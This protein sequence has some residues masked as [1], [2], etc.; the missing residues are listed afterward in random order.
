VIGQRSYIKQPRVSSREELLEQIRQRRDMNDLLQNRNAGLCS[1][2]RMEGLPD[3][4]STSSGGPPSVLLIDGYNVVRS[5][6]GLL[7]LIHANS[8]ESAREGLQQILEAFAGSTEA[9]VM[10]VWDAIGYKGFGSEGRQDSLEEQG[11]LWILWSALAE[12]D[13]LILRMLTKARLDGAPHVTIITEDREIADLAR[14]EGAYVLKGST[15]LRDL[16]ERANSALKEQKIEL[17]VQRIKEMEAVRS[18]FSI[19]SGWVSKAQARRSGFKSARDWHSAF[20]QG[21]DADT[22]YAQREAHRLHR[23]RQLRLINSQ[24]ARARERLAESL[25]PEGLLAPESALSDQESSSPQDP[26]IEDKMEGASRLGTVEGIGWVHEIDAD[27]IAVHCK[28]SV[29]K[30]AVAVFE[31]RLRCKPSSDA[32]LS[33]HHTSEKTLPG[34][35]TCSGT[36][37]TTVAELPQTSGHDCLEAGV[38]GEVVPAPLILR[39]GAGQG[40]DRCTSMVQHGVEAHATVDSGHCV[41]ELGGSPLTRRMDKGSSDSLRGPLTLEE[42][43]AALLQTQHPRSNRS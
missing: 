23:Q 40:H 24:S 42:L 28:K 34:S 30:Q 12:A 7:R 27:G 16:A 11:E 17:D 9:R 22:Y 5:H 15:F 1:P 6:P 31:P 37:D 10:L 18:V 2:L 13:S 36:S 29:C 32:P 43:A 20:K 4:G 14:N 3:I 35:D 38:S 25:L 41:E 19:S 26:S 39:T 33:D 8:M 21:V